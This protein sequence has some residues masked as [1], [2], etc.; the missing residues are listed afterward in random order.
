MINKIE[1]FLVLFH[2][3]HDFHIIFQYY[4]KL[5]W[6]YSGNTR[7]TAKRKKYTE[8]IILNTEKNFLQIIYNKD[9]KISI[10]IIKINNKSS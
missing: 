8:K 10:K 1:F 9:E 3:E 4:L 6:I 2:C 5:L 7:D